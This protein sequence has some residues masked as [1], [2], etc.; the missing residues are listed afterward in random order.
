MMCCR[1]GQSCSS[2]LQSVNASEGKLQSTSMSI[3]RVST[4]IILSLI[5]LYFNADKLNVVRAV[6][7]GDQ[8]LF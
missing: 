5:W 6:V 8:F 4:W 2:V 7:L 1:A 3:R